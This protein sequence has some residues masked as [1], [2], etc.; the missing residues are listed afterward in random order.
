M[1]SLIYDAGIDAGVTSV[2]TYTSTR[3][4]TQHQSKISTGSAL[5]LGRRQFWMD[6]RTALPLVIADSAA[7]ATTA[8]IATTLSTWAGE[9]VEQGFIPVAVIITLLAQLFHGLYPACGMSYSIEFRKQLQTAAY[10]SAGLGLGMFF[11]T[12]FP[13]LCWLSFSVLFPAL[14]SSSRSLTRYV[15][16]SQDWWSQPILVVG[17]GERAARLFDRLN[18]LSTEGLRPSGIVYDPHPHWAGD[19]KRSAAWEQEQVALA[20]AV[21]ARTKRITPMHIGPISELEDILLESGA[22][23]IAVADRNGVSSSQ[24][25]CFHGIPHV[26]VPMELTSH[27]TE[28]VR[29]VEADGRVEMH[30]KTT[31]TCPQALFTKRAMDLLLVIGSAPFWL[32]VMIIIG[33]AVRLTDPGPV[34]YRQSRVGRFRRPFDALKFRSMCCD[35]DKKLNNY[36]ENNPEMKAEWD[37]THKLRNDPRITRIGRFIRKTSLDELPQLI[38]VLRGEMSLVGPRPIIDSSSYDREYIQEHPD[39]F[40]MYQMVR[41]GITG[42]WQVSGRNSTSYKQRIYYDRFYLHNWSIATDIFILWRTI[43]TALFREGAC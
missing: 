32:P 2:R 23:R 16:S 35:A 31:L 28:N 29:L 24:F 5:E 17:N 27:P 11:G 22:C 1:S 42:M 34:F 6:V 21:T 25:A 40:E 4:D 15:L 20:N 26:A 30:C 39:V 10:V 19:S 13:W 41:P 9:V 18:K 33:L 12:G 7:T 3:V 38:N 8:T 36:L 14:L 37:A 43:K